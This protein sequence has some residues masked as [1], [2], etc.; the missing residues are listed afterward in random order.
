MVNFEAAVAILQDHQVLLVKREDFE[1][2]VLPGGAIDP[3]ESVLDAAV[4]EAREETGLVVQLTR[5]V[6][7]YSRPNWASHIIVFAAEQTGG[8]ARAQAGEV[9]DVRFFDVNALPADLKV[10]SPTNPRCP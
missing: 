1:V 10:V 2:W 8:A 9:I 3:G 4:R 5:L 7:I 6:G